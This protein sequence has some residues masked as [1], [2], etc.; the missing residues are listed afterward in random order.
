MVSVFGDKLE[1]SRIAAVPHEHRMPR[2][3]VNLSGKPDEFTP[4]V[5]DTKGREV[6]P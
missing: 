3:V 5:N 1:F 6:A 2:L 4:S